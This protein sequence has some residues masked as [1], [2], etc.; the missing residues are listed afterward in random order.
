MYVLFMLLIRYREIMAKPKL[1]LTANL[2]GWSYFEHRKTDKTFAR[3]AAK[4]LERDKNTC[5]FCRFHAERRQQIVNV[6]GNYQNNVPSNL[7]TACVFCA[8]CFFIGGRDSGKII[9]LPEYSQAEL[10]HMARILLCAIVV[11][12]N[13]SDRAKTLYRSFRHRAQIIDDS[14][15]AGMSDASTFGRLLIDAKID[16]K[17]MQVVDSMRFLPARSA[18]EDEITY[19]SSLIVPKLDEHILSI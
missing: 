14:F 5:R 15:G 17:S 3:L 16:A 19:W 10:N 18:F 13:Y 2:E 11:E 1:R 8:E 12:K 6:D 9:V 7:V 4:I